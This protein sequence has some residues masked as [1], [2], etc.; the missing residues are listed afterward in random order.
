[1]VGWQ[2]TETPKGVAGS[3]RSTRSEIKKEAHTMKT[4]L[5]LNGKKTTRKNIIALIGETR[6]DRYIRESEREYWDDPL[7]V[8]D[9]MVPGGTLTIRFD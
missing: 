7:V 5:Y 8:N 6:L 4:T 9:Y 3:R 2:P 1:M